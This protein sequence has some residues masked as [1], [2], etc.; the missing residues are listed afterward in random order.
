MK[1]L[2][3][4]AIFTIVSL[5]LSAQA[6]L[7][8]DVGGGLGTATTKIDGEDISDSLDSDIEFAVDINAKVGVGPIA[9]IP[10]YLVADLGVCRHNY[11]ALI[12]YNLVSYLIGP[13]LVVYPFPALQISGSAGYSWTANETSATYL[14][15]YDSESGY[16]YNVSAAFDFGKRNNGFLLGARYF[17]SNNTLETSKAEQETSMISIFAKYAYRHKK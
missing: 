14:T 6:A 4:L 7:Y 13:G 8:F 11:Y 9:N 10:V 16:A 3:I 17:Y 12:D 1:R 15:M 5:S 2:S